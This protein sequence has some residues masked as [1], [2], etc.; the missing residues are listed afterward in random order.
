MPRKKIALIATNISI[1]NQIHIFAE[2]QETKFYHL[3]KKKFGQ[4]FSA[5]NSQPLKGHH[6]FK[7]DCENFHFS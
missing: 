6:Y 5:D 2:I 7:S 1:L 4:T 3:C